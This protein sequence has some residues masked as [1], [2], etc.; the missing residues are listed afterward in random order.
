MKDARV[1]KLLAVYDGPERVGEIEDRG[2]QRVEAFVGIG[3]R[4]RSLGTFKTRLDAMR[5]IPPSSMRKIRNA[6]ARPAAV[7][8]EG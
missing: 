1:S 4:R 2:R 6:S 3:K 7:A 8:R 5:V